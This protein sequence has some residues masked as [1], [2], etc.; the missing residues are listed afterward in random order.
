MPGLVRKVLVFAAVDGLILQPAP[1]RNH[2]PTTQQAI[3]ID[4][5][6]NVGPL[7]K[8]RREESTAP[9]S[10][11]T[12]GIIGLLKIASSSFLISICG[13]EQVAQIHG[14]P[15]YKITDVS[16]I[17]LSSQA[18][19]DQAIVT[20]NEHLARHNRSSQTGESDEAS[21]N[22]DDESQSISGDSLDDDVTPPAQEIKDPLTGQKGPMDRRG[23]VVEDVIGKKGVYG[24][25]ADKWFSRKGWSTESR[26]MQGMSSEDDLT[27][28]NMAKDVDSIMPGEAEQPIRPGA[29]PVSDNDVKDSVSPG[30]IPKAMEGSTDSTTV[31]LLPK[32]LK[33]AKMYFGSGNFFFSYDYDLS[34]GIGKQQKNS[35]LPLY[36]QFEP[37]YFW[38]QHLMSPFIEVGQHNF[39][40]PVIQGFVGQ[41]SF[42]L[43]G[44]D[45]RSTSIMLDPS[46]NP[47]DIHLKSYPSQT[48]EQVAAS[49]GDSNTA[50]EE[51]PE[52]KEFLLTLVSRRSVKRAGLRYLRRGIDEEGNVANSVETEQ[53]LSSPEWEIS[54]DRIFSFTQYRGSIPLFFS[55]S[56]YSL[57]PQV[58]FWGSPETNAK[59]FKRHFVDI[60][61]RYGSIYC[62]SLVDKHGTESKIGEEYEKQAAALNEHGGIDGRGTKLGFEWFDFHNV[63]RGMHFENVSKLMDSLAPFLKE[64][65]WTEIEKGEATYQQSGVLRTNCMDCL[66][67]TNVVQSACA[68]AA[69]EAQLSAQNLSIDLQND[70]STSWFNNLWADNGD[71]ISKQYAGTAALKGDF[72]RTRK[73]NALG[74]LSDFG[75][76]L[77]RYYNNIVNDYFAQ[78][79]IDFMLG[80]ATDSIFAEFEADMKSSDYFVDLKKV[81]QAAI[82]RSAG[83]VIEDK[84]EDLVAGWT[85]SVPSAANALKTAAFEEAVLLLTDRALYF[86][87]LDWGTEKVKTF[88]R[89]DLHDI[90]EIGR[91]VYITSTLAQRHM[92]VEKN[93]GFVIQYRAD[94]GMAMVRRNTR[95]LD[96]GVHDDKAKRCSAKQDATGRFLAFKALPPRSAVS[97]GEGADPVNEVEMVKGVCE[98]IAKVANKAR[99]QQGALT[100]GEGVAKGLLVVE[101]RDV[102]SLADA[103]KSTGYLEQL[104]YSLKKLVWA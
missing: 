33:T 59:A 16:L 10:L 82:E 3:K 93:V 42:N 39:V 86:C 99:S 95:S 46:H 36:K 88:E 57:K 52:S 80:R 32:I 14:K 90:E 84:D 28:K 91:G 41:R 98:E 30:D 100:E 68:Q 18:D 77:T 78:A 27:Q 101:E 11:E 75:L 4:Y 19:A 66:D 64:T 13:R 24:R 103:K 65:G 23:S 67:R 51:S 40:L 21:D 17:P 58:Q 81:R 29:I 2:L 12:H 79:L 35:S 48:D 7:L 60:S 8:D 89:I 55:Q 45:S 70:P 31:T 6:G 50:A 5:K 94:E 96:S 97:A 73:R 61:S 53:I 63:C 71:A 62:A 38:N 85:L 87:R 47:D 44:V 49:Q 20:A 83:I 72:T 26:R 54:N 37:L 92:D 104:G 74:A 56:P 15:I 9:V 43:K 1:P 34:H 76:T 69:L 102:I 22:S 25:F